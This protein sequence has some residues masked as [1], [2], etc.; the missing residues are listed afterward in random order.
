MA[1]RAPNAYEDSPGYLP[2][3]SSLN[4]GGET[5]D[6]LEFVV[7]HRFGPDLTLRASAY[8]WRLQDMLLQSALTDEFQNSPPVGARGLELS[9]DRTWDSGARLRGS[10]SLQGT[11]FS[12]GGDLPNSPHLLA[13]VNDS[14]PLPWAGLHLGAEMRYDG[15]RL[16]L[17][18]DAVGGYTVANLYLGSGALAPGLDVS[19]AVNNVFDKHYLQPAGPNNW[20]YVLEQDGRSV[21]LRLS[22]AF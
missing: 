17:N 19:L 1:H 15:P 13:K 9:A 8:E 14:A 10:V 16:A 6:T 4:L 18:G 12:A 20:Q 7:D 3:P 11:G 21:G 2:G 5:I 22:Y